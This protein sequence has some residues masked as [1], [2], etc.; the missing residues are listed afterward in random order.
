MRSITAVSRVAWA[1]LSLVVITQA[2]PTST[3]H[4][5][6]NPCPA[7]CRGKPANWTVY[8]SLVRLDV[9]DQPQ[10]LDFALYN[11][12]DDAN[13]I[14]KISACTAGNANNANNLMGPTKRSAPVCIPNAKE[15]KVSLN[16]FVGDS[17]GDASADH[18]YSALEQVQKYFA[19]ES[20]CDEKI[21]FG[22]APGA[23]IGVYTGDAIDT[24]FTASSLLQRL[25]DEVEKGKVPSSAVLQL[26]GDERNADHTFGVAINTAGNL[27]AAKIRC[28]LEQRYLRQSQ[29][30]YQQARRRQRIGEASGGSQQ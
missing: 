20:N 5:V 1:A 16:L 19:D 23:V 3:F 13:S 14:V 9:C 6:F 25:R 2:E 11:F 22:Y 18:L 8:S 27:A 17:E 26:C 28:S 12:V 30:H 29:W 21:I 15:S 24:S 10:L 7:S 4:S